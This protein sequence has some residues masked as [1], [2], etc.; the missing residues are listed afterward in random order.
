MVY[1]RPSFFYYKLQLRARH[2]VSQTPGGV[3]IVCPY[4]VTVAAMTPTLT[5]TK[6]IFDRQPVVD[7]W[8]YRQRK[9]YSQA[10]HGLSMYK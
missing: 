4:T 2:H 7:H 10:F 6:T 5:L 8:Y 9:Q 1:R 3:S